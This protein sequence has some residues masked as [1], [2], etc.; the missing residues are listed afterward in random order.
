MYLVEFVGE[1]VVHAEDE[2]EAKEQLKDDLNLPMG[3]ITISNIK[4]LD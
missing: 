2:D 3:Q 4:E 1:A